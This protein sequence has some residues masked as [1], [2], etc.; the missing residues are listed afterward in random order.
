M[1]I[2]GVGKEIDPNLDVFE[3]V[4][5]YFLDLLR[6]RYSP[7]K[8]A[9]DIWRGVERLS[10]TA[11]DLPQQVREVMEDLRMGRLT[12]RTHDPEQTKSIDRLGRRVLTGLL[13]SS[14]TVAG[15]WLVAHQGNLRWLGIA[16]ILAA[17][18]WLFWHVVL[19]LRR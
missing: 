7:E 9:V 10:T 8:I 18:T 11:Y 2:E 6:R 5:P 19:D 13:V 1:T 16:L 14:A 3:E 4:R 15:S 17:A 12:V